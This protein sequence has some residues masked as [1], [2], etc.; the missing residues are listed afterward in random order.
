[1]SASPEPQ[2]PPA[3]DCIACA[4]KDPERCPASKRPC[5]HHCNHSW[6]RYA[7]HW[8]G[9]EWL[10]ASEPPAAVAQPPDLY[11]VVVERRV[12]VLERTLLTVEGTSPDQARAAGLALAGHGRRVWHEVG[13][14]PRAPFRVRTVAPTSERRDP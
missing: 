1:M 6:T 7:C 11:D 12:L 10:D 4:E 5:G 13:R 9:K 2:A 14:A 8:C 3:G